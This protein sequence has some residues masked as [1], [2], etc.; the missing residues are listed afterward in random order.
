MV[1]QNLFSDMAD[2]I[3]GRVCH[4]PCRLWKPL[5]SFHRTKKNILGRTLECRECSKDRQSKH[6]EFW[7]LKNL[8]IGSEA[9][10]IE[11]KESRRKR[12]CCFCKRLLPLDEYYINF[13]RKSGFSSECHKCDL[14]RGAKRRS[15]SC[16]VP[17]EIGPEDFSIP[18][19]CPVLGSEMQ[20]NL[21]GKHL[22]DASPTLDRIIPDRG[23]VPG[24]VIVISALAN[25]IKNSAIDPSIFDRVA[26]YLRNPIYNPQP[27]PE[28][29]Q[30]LVDA[31]RDAA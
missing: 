16:K 6:R 14:M 2:S 5:D 12:K 8:S 9:L 23:Y 24:N 15:V 22:S 3:P 4:G 25:K 1:Q 30:G 21:G 18:K 13:G 28:T 10:M 26:A 31:I 20:R 7:R 19:V 27:H 11:A 17:F 29:E